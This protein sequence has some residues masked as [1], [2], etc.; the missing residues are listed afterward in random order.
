MTESL[1]N[2]EDGLSPAARAALAALQAED[3]M[4]ADARARV[5][6]RVE[7]DVAGAEL[8]ERTGRRWRA[9]ALIGLA[10]AAG[11]V[12]ALAGIRGTAA[13]VAVDAAG[14][15]AQYGGESAGAQGAARRGGEAGAKEV[16]ATNPEVAAEATASD[17]AE[18]EAAAAAA[19]APEPADRSPRTGRKRQVVEAVQEE[20]AAAPVEVGPK[21]GREAALLQQAQA[22]LA[23]SRAAEAL[24]HLASYDREFGADGVLR[25]EHDALR[26]VALCAAGRMAEGKA[27]A[28]RFLGA[29]AG[30]VQAERVR[31]ACAGAP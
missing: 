28:D 1:H 19:T 23:G 4:P 16:A 14:P 5:W 27:A 29:H 17:A 11:L 6:E 2:Q 9:G 7:Q 3:D 18:P 31:G 26:A 24:A 8:A 21:L 13:P 25:T 15:A 22:A 30:S 12:L 10:L 20:D